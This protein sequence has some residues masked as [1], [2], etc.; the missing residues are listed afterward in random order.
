[1]AQKKGTK[2]RKKVKYPLFIEDV[3]YYT[4]SKIF[5]DYYCYDCS[6]SDIFTY[7]SG[8]FFGTSSTIKDFY[9][10]CYSDAKVEYIEKYKNSNVYRDFIQYLNKCDTETAKSILQCSELFSLSKINYEPKSESSSKKN[11]DKLITDCFKA[12]L[13]HRIGR[14]LSSSSFELDATYESALDALSQTPEEMSVA[15][16]NKSLKKQIIESR[17]DYYTSEVESI[18][19][20]VEDIKKDEAKKQQETER[21]KNELTFYEKKK[22]IDIEA[23]MRILDLERQFMEVT[24]KIAQEQ[25]ADLRKLQQ[26][27]ADF[28][29]KQITQMKELLNSN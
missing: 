27:Q 26:E 9:N 15:Y 8:F 17:Y 19:Q 20:R 12:T 3:S 13:F 1:M 21:N 2:G 18:F 25:D 6:I 4:N 29:F 22:N 5:H 28:Y 14:N 23:K 11:A 7:K 10:S 24:Q 16:G